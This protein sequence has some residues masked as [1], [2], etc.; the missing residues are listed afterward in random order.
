MEYRRMLMAKQYLTRFDEILCEMADKMLNKQFCDNITIDFIICMI[1]HHEAAIKMCEN[2]L[3]Y[4]NYLPLQRVAKNIIQMQKK[5]IEQMTEILR[6]TSG[7]CNTKQKVQSY[8]Q[9]YL[10]ITNEM[11]NKMKNS[12]RCYSINLDFVGEMI[13]HHEGAIQMCHN[14]LKYYIDP[15]LKTVAESII[16]E[17]SRGVIELKNIQRNL[18]TYR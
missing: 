10:S 6:T 3:K 18:C 14:L 9:R 12:P 13:P 11:V 5:G 15:R 8:L 17:Q 4:T 16:Q 1:P 2:L 7:Y